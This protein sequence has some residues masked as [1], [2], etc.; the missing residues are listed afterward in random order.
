MI[1]FPPSEALVDHSILTLELALKAFGLPSRGAILYRIESILKGSPSPVGGDPRVDP[2]EFNEAVSLSYLLHDI[3][4]G[5]AWYQFRL[6]ERPSGFP[7]HEVLSAYV[8]KEV[9]EDLSVDLP[10]V[11]KLVTWI[12]VLLHHQAMRDLGAYA[13]HLENEL[14][15]VCASILSIKPKVR[16]EDIEDI[17]L[18]T[19]RV[20][21]FMKDIDPNILADSVLNAMERVDF[22]RLRG[23]ICRVVTMA[24]EGRSDENLELRMAFRILPLILVPLQL[25]DATA[26]SLLRPYTTPLSSRLALETLRLM[27]TRFKLLRRSKLPDYSKK[28]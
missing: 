21:R 18:L 15:E 9:L 28:F 8:V 27:E 3:G 6:R 2:S 11:I 19:K 25:A 17:V 26:A 4:K 20:R 10:E 1:S 12:S 5:M 14:R 13:K 16:G 24:E 22:G 7:F 23:L